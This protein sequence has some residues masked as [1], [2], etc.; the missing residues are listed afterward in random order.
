MQEYNR[1]DLIIT[2]FDA[3]DV[4]TTSGPESAIYNDNNSD[5]P[6]VL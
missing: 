6:Y 3:E 1:T 4:I 5:N 2:E